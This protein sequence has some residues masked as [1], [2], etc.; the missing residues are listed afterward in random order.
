[1]AAAEVVVV[2]LLEVMGEPPLLGRLFQLPVAVVVVALLCLLVNLAL[3]AAGM[4]VIV[5]AT[6]VEVAAVAWGEIQSLAL[7]AAKRLLVGRVIIYT[8]IINLLLYLAQ[9]LLVYMVL[10][11][12]VEVLILEEA[13]LL[14][15]RAH[16]A[17]EEE[18]LILLG[19]LLALQIQA[20]AVVVALVSLV[21]VLAAQV[22][23]EFGGLNKE[24]KWN[25]H[26]SKLT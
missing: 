9:G 5:Q 11:V 25:T 13:L 8:L 4:L 20:A 7:T 24:I 19:G 15:L 3:A 6:L 23:A 26:S 18:V 2:L 17:A 1:L 14:L 22:F 21:A 10:L 16:Q 12:V